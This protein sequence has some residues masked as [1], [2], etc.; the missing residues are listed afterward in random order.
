MRIFYTCYNNL[1]RQAGD[2]RHIMEIAENLK[3]LGHEILVFAPWLGEYR[4]RNQVQIVY[5]PLVNMPILNILS[6]SLFLFFYLIFHSLKEKP[7]IVYSR[8]MGWSITTALFTKLIKRPLIIEVQIFYLA[9]ELGKKGLQFIKVKMLEYILNIS[10]K[11][12]DRILTTTEKTKEKL[13][14]YYSPFPYKI[15]V[16]PSGANVDL[17]RP[18][19][20]KHVR[21][22]LQLEQDLYWVGMVGTLYPHQG[23]DYLINSLPFIL[24]ELPNLKL[25]II[26][27]GV[28]KEELVNLTR[29]LGVEDKVVFTGEV[30][31]EEVPKYINALDVCVAFFKPV[32]PYTADPIKLYEY[33]ACEKAVVTSGLDWCEDF[34]EQVGN[35]VSVEASNPQKLAKAIVQ[36]IKDDN[37]RKETGKRG[38]EIVVEQRR[39][40]I[41]AKNVQAVLKEIIDKDKLNN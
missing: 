18:M 12:A 9:E 11:A 6:Y 19:N 16:V 17:F 10:L 5:V 24:K 7:D 38:R 4:Q 34:L 37:L 35:L 23:V 33:L 13:S 14:K 28:M 8:Q 30:P 36:L 2:V 27:N 26:G 20:I 1:S 39:W 32:L 15:T 29:D 41:A 3:R 25:I 21:K 31:Y 22:D 40:E